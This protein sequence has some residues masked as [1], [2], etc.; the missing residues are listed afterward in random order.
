MSEFSEYLDNYMDDHS[1]SSI[2][3][4]KVTGIDRT[5][6]HRYRRGKRI[7]ADEAT[8]KLIADS[9]RMTVQERNVFMDRYDYEIMG[10]LTVK[11]YKYV[12]DMLGVFAELEKKDTAT[13]YSWNC[14]INN[15]PEQLVVELN[16]ENEIL[17]YMNV[18]FNNAKDND[19]EIHIIMQPVYDAL[20]S[21]MGHLFGDGEVRVTH[22]ICLEQSYS[23]SYVNL[24]S[25]RRI[26]PMCFTNRLYN[27][28]YYYDSLEGHINDMSFL[29]NIVIAGKCA[30]VFDYDMKHGMMI[31][32]EAYIEVL[33]HEYERIRSKS[34]SFVG[35]EYDQIDVM[36]SYNIINP[37]KGF[38]SLFNQPCMAIGIS[39]DIYE[40]FLYPFP[41]K[42]EFIKL[43]TD[44]LGDWEGNEYKPGKNGL[45][46][47][48]CAYSFADGF[49]YFM[50]TGRVNEF[51]EGYYSAL[52][53]EA[54]KEVFSRIFSI[55]GNGAMNY[56]FLPDDIEIPNNLFFYFD[57]S[58]KNVLIHKVF[59][60]RICRVFV[61]EAGI[62]QA[63]MSFF[64]YL[65][66][67]HLLCT[68]QD[69]IKVL[70]EIEREY[71]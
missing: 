15:N 29:P 28:L 42:K 7:P 43:M 63:F 49:R 30:I 40:R 37:S 24:E 32:D 5:A 10:S 12:K 57:N 27:V 41:E 48:G 46:S 69:A 70:K 47:G 59:E 44:R 20:I 54:R 4:S 11:G 33:M 3:L 18:L 14:D 64:E 25:F 50:K 22:I 58:K 13:S 26:L 9:L 71:M 66:K 8:V 67:K 61:E 35:M 38:I 19:C 45:I 21:M 39:S 52:D 65:E 23:R 68:G 2:E 36:N 16:S 62:F 53:M 34:V 17:S 55:A 6:I 60:D 1:I 51:P 31:R 56:C